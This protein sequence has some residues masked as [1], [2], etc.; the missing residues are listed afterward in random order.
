MKMLACV[1]LVASLAAAV[2]TADPSSPPAP[3]PTCFELSLDGRLWSRTPQ[4]LCI[5]PGTKQVDITLKIGMPTPADVATF[6]LDLR[7]RARCS[8]CN[9]DEF[10]LTDPSNSVLNALAITFDGRRDV[11]AGTEAGT[12]SIG[13][14]RFHY[15]RAR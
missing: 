13:K 12:V 5:G 10:A 14:T 8:D 9:R 15:R 11:Q 3:S 4:L 7:S 1:V 2:A 6:H